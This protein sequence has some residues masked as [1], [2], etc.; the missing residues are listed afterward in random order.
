MVYFLA[1]VFFLWM[2]VVSWSIVNLKARNKKMAADFTKLNSVVDKL[3]TD[4]GALIAAQPPD[5]L[6]GVG[7]ILLLLLN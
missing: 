1:A 2:L 5:V 4:V 6:L 3:K 7:Q